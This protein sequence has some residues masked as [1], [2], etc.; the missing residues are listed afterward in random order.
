MGISHD[1]TKQPV[2][3]APA[4]I[5]ELRHDKTNSDRP[6]SEDSN[7]P[8]HPPSLTRVFAV[9]MKKAWVLSY[10][11]SAKRRL[12]SDLADAQADLS[13]RWAHSHFVSFG[14]SRLICDAKLSPVGERPW[15]N[16]QTTTP[17]TWLVSSTKRCESLEPTSLLG[18]S[19]CTVAKRWR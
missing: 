17:K 10:P 9:R 1:A 16:T 18:Y 11:L 15:V 12:W 8:G 6:P 7:Q 13:L 5:Y 14:M 3:W 4:L 2:S 19:T